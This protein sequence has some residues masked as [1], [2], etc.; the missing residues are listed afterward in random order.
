MIYK[1]CTSSVHILFCSSGTA[2]LDW[3]YYALISIPILFTVVGLIYMI[4]K[5]CFPKMQECCV[6]LEKEDLNNEYG[7][8]YDTSGEMWQDRMEVTFCHTFNVKYNCNTI[9]INTDSFSQ[10]QDRN[11]AYETTY[12]STSDVGQVYD[13]DYMG[14]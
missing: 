8:Y 7:T 4:R 3:V 5:I 13:Y 1:I 11:P 10:V 2:N 14:D 9:T 12:N 6:D